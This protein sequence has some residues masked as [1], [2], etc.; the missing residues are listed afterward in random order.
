MHFLSSI[1]IHLLN[2]ALIALSEYKPGN[3]VKKHERFLVFKVEFNFEISCGIR[4]L[5]VG[6]VFSNW[7]SIIIKMTVIN[8]SRKS[9][10]LK[11]IYFFFE[12][13]RDFFNNVFF[14]LSGVDY[15]FPIFDWL[16]F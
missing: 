10:S 16:C 15:C 8:C 13:R 12:I 6:P 9:K 5:P 2:V 1:E 3:G 14:L 7:V 11:G 4:I